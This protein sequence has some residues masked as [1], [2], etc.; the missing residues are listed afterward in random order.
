M[1]QCLY[2]PEEGYY[3]QKTGET[4]SKEGDFIT[5]VSVGK[6]FGMLLSRRLL[7]FWE[8]NERSEDFAIIEVGAHDG[9]LAEDILE[10]LPE[11]SPEFAQA[12][13]YF[14]IEPL[15]KRK[16]FLE[17]K[18]GDRVTILETPEN[19][20]EKGALLANEVLDALPVSLLLFSQNSWHEIWVN[21]EEELTWFAQPITNPE[22]KQLTETLG[23]NYPEGYVT[24]APPEFHAFFTSLNGLFEEGLMTFIDYGLDAANLYSTSRAAGTF[25]CYRKQQSLSHPLDHPGKQDLTADVNFSAAEEAAQSL[26]LIPC[27]IMHQSRFLTYCAQNWLLSKEPPTGSILNQFQT[28]IHPG[29]FGSRFYF[30]ELLKGNVKRAFP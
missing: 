2:H 14:I 25:R 29:Q 9:S 1:A 11:I 23:K 19:V 13:Q 5:S 16:K 4:V 7:R 17:D 8:Q 24:E 18:F 20:S 22:L 10:T 27:P 28:L 3:A 12:A 26:G 30:L 6:C 15:P 21:F